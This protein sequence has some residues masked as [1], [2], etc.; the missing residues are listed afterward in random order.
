VRFQALFAIGA[1]GHFV[2]LGLEVLGQQ[3]AQVLV[4]LAQEDLVGFLHVQKA[5]Q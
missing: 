1:K 4:I 2:A 3:A 5:I